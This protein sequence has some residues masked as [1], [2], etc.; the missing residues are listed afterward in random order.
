MHS[1]QEVRVRQESRYTDDALAVRSNVRRQIPSASGRRPLQKT[2]VT[3]TFVSTFPFCVPANGW[4]TRGRSR[5]AAAA[6]ACRAWW[7][8]CSNASI[9]LARRGNGYPDDSKRAPQSREVA[10]NVGPSQPALNGTGSP[11]RPGTACW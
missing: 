8:A 11:G 6:G 4:L 7:T 5:I 10:Q 2:S 9:V 3:V 1:Q